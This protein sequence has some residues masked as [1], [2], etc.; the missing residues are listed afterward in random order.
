MPKSPRPST[1]VEHYRAVCGGLARS[2]VPLDDPRYLAAHE[3]L[4]RHVRV[5][6]IEKL[7][8]ESPPLTQEQRDRLAELLKPALIRRGD[9]GRPYVTPGDIE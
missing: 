4:R 1:V 2:G 8:A 5:E 7:V 6:K 3:E 9:D